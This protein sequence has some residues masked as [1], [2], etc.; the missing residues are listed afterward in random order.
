MMGKR[1][2]FSL[3]SWS[4]SLYSVAHFWWKGDWIFLIF[5]ISSFTLAILSS[6]STMQILQTKNENKELKTKT[7]YCNIRE[8]QHV[9]DMKAADLEITKLHL[10]FDFF[11]RRFSSLPGPGHSKLEVD[12]G[13]ICNIW[14]EN[15]EQ[16]CVGDIRLLNTALS[17][18]PSFSS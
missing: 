14:C 3:F 5:L 6:Q 7:Y 13:A 9:Q 15:R 11:C 2:R 18:F 4:L 17:I 1:I 10:Y 8:Q 16:I 12:R